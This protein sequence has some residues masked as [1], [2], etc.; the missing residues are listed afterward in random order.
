LTIHDKLLSYVRLSGFTDT[1][2]CRAR[3]LEF[4]N[5]S[6]ITLHP[7]SKALS[8]FYLTTCCKK[9]KVSGVPPQ[10]DQRLPPTK[11]L[12]HY[13]DTFLQEC[14][15]QLVGPR[16]RENIAVARAAIVYRGLKPLPQS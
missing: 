12:P 16:L 2:F 9:L 14:G 3:D 11:H 6:N 7:F 5:F 10:A 4:N 13:N 15:F 8:G 1:C